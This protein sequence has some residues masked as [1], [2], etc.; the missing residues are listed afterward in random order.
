MTNE[1][2]EIDLSQSSATD[3]EVLAVLSARIDTMLEAEPD[4]LMSLLYRLD[5]EEKAI[6]QALEPGH[7]E[8]A[9][10]ALAKIVLERQKQRSAT[11]KKIEVRPLENPEEWNL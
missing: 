8:P 5:I 2:L 10:L 1:S 6:L 11:K 4:L 3:E 7:H 9:A